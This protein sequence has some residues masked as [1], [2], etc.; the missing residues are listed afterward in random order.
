MSQ[1]KR[2]LGAFRDGFAAVSE[3]SQ[4]HALI[5]EQ[6]SQIAG[7]EE[8]V[9]ALKEQLG[10]LDPD[11][12]GSTGNVV[13]VALERITIPDYQPRTY[14]NPEKLASLAASIAK[15]GV[16]SPVLLRKVPTGEGYE[17]IAGLRRFLGSKR[18]ERATIP[19][20]ISEIDDE[21][22]VQLA[23]LENAQ[24]EDLNALDETEGVLR[25][26]STSLK[27][28]RE[29]VIQLFQQSKSLLPKRDQ[30]TAEEIES[31][32]H[33]EFF[34]HWQSVEGLFENAIGRLSTEAFRTHRLPLLELPEDIRNAIRTEQIGY[35]KA[36]LI[37]RVEDTDERERILES[38]IAEGWSRSRISQE[39]AALQPDVEEDLDPEKE[40]LTR[41][42]NALKRLKKSDALRNPGKRKKVETLLSRLEAV[43]DS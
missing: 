29:R 33:A 38:A 11:A 16:Q 6:S 12:A 4:Q 21:R 26:L 31:G 18:A 36:R 22:A 40:L 23:V 27:L 5:A 13:S 25:L 41:A 19:A 2:Q 35:S 32:K 28:E 14:V 8:Q 37:S 10:Q 39:I 24:R 17:L 9:R 3:T 42:G 1:S 30:I 43:L 34:Q 15:Y 7:L 20:L